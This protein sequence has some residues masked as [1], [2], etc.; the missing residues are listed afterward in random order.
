MYDL[1]SL[2]DSIFP[3]GFLWGSATAGH[4]IEGNNIHANWWHKE[5]TE[6]WAEP[7]GSA[8]DHWTRWREDFALLTALGHRAYRL[9]IEWSRIEPSEGQR[10]AAALAQYLAM[11]A[12]L[13]ARGIKVCVTLHH[14]THPQ[15]FEEK[16]GFCRRENLAHFQRH[17]DFLVPKIAPYV[18]FWTVIN[19][20]N[21]HRSEWSAAFKETMLRAHVHGYAAIKAQHAA[22]VSSAHAYVHYQPYRY[23]DA[24]DRMLTEH[25]DWEANGFFFHAVRTGALVLPHTDAVTIPGLT[26]S[27]DYWAVNYYTRQLIDARVKHGRGARYRHKAIRF[28]NREFY[29]EEMFPEAL[30]ASLE[31]IADKPVY[32]T[33]NGMAC[34]DDR[35][36][37]LYLV[38]HLN[39]L[40]EALDRGVDV[41]GYLHWSLMDNY[42][43]GSFVPR[44]GL[45]DVDRK[46]MARTPKPS[47]A[48]YREV[49]AANGVTQAM[50]RTYLGD[51]PQLTTY[52]Q[53]QHT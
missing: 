9:S 43:W 31:R 49:I 25:L 16:G 46:T 34:D 45:V 13:K 6:K 38:L 42:E 27:M 5:V 4:Q 48:F 7:S 1:P 32:I 11:L 36:R 3:A 20:F 15:W 26:G 10:D 47:A 51:W 39:A 8:C 44:F 33:E 23:Y 41:R 17:V 2:G 12:D 21:L 53:H 37:V 22:P 52:P 50:L 30:I 18:D 19:E 28:I 14:F 29:L 24:A 35:W 40:R